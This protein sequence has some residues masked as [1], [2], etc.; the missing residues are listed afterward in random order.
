MVTQLV[1]GGGSQKNK[2]K[3]NTSVLPSQVPCGL[4]GDVAEVCK[5]LGCGAVSAG[6]VQ[7]REPSKGRHVGGDEGARGVLDRRDFM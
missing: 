4:V 7:P 5:A 2:D 1:S 3:Q 6:V